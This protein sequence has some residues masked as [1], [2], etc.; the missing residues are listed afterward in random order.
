M[1]IYTKT[2]D[3]GKTSL[4]GGRGASKN[5]LRIKSYGEVD[6]LNSYIGTILSQSKTGEINSRLLRVQNELFVLGTDLATPQ[7]VKINVP[8]ISKPFVTRLEKDIDFLQ[9][10]LPQIKNFIL[11]GGSGTGSQLHFARTIVRRTERSIADLVEN[12]KI[13]LETLRYINR[14]SDWFFVLARYVNKLDNVKEVYWRG[15]TKT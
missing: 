11:P 12:E 5:S 2:G 3:K 9:K 13:N 10:K 6:E 8:R 1:K 4:F 14:L 15:K 7:D